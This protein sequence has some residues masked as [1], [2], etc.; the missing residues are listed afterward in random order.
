MSMTIGNRLA[1]RT[2][3]SSA[4]QGTL[5]RR[6]RSSAPSEAGMMLLITRVASRRQ[7]A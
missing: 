7:I 1:G 5:L 3:Y 6:P 2:G 4:F